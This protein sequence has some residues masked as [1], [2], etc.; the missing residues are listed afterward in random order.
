MYPSPDNIRSAPVWENYLVA[1]A[2]Q[3]SL[4]LIPVNALAVGVRVN[5]PR[6]H[7]VIQLRHASTHDFEDIDDIRSMLEDLVGPDV[8]VDVDA[9]HVQNRLISPLDGTHWI[10]LRRI[11][12]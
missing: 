6:V 4:G 3:A 11:E 10:Y 8:S 2:V 12:D 1:Q 5:G 7:L 9:Q